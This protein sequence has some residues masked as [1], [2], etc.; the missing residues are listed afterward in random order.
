MG[1][2]GQSKAAAGMGSEASGSALAA[3]GSEVVPASVLVLVAA[4]A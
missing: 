2:V 3:I 1:S 4:S